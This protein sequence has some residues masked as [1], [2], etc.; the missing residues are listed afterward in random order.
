MFKQLVYLGTPDGLLAHSLID[1]ARAWSANTGGISGAL[2]FGPDFVA[3][4]NANG[5]VVLVDAMEGG[6]RGRLPGAAPWP[7]VV[8]RDG[9]LYATKDA[10]MLYDP[11][12]AT[13]RRWMATGWLG[14]Q[15]SPLVMA[16]SAVYFATDKRGLV[17]VGKYR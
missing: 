7:P 8:T 16:D 1:G 9:V 11:T 15:V 14:E 13:S 17:K 10:L 12:D 2:V 3:A 4:T 6:I 5:E